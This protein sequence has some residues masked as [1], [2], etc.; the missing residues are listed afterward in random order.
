MDCGIG[1]A[2]PQE[3]TGASNQDMH[4]LMSG[5]NQLMVAETKR[6]TAAE[7]CTETTKT[8]TGKDKMQLFV[9]WMV[10]NE[11]EE[12]ADDTVDDS[13]NLVPSQTDFVDV[14][15]RQSWNA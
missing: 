7:A 12:I 8:K 13:G 14:Y 6:N 9:V 3:M 11:L 15:T 1:M 2:P 5:V 10:L 4:N